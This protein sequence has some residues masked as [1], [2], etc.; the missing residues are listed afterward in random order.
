MARKPLK[1]VMGPVYGLDKTD[2]DLLEC[3]VQNIPMKRIGTPDDMANAVL[4]LL[5][6]LSSYVTGQILCVAGG[7]V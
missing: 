3:V 6:D 7:M 1:T 5:S 4:F 2:D